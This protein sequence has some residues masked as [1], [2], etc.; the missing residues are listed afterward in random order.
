MS[1]RF[2]DSFDHYATAS[3]P[4]KWTYVLQGT[5][6]TTIAAGS[7][8]NG[9]QSLHFPSG[10]TSPTVTKTFDGNQT[11][12]VVGF[13]MKLSALP[14]AYAPILTFLQAQLQ[15][16]TLGINS[17]G[18]LDLRRGLNTA[19]TGGASTNTISTGTWYYV[20]T[21][22]KPTT[23][24]AASSCYV[25]VGGV[26][27]LT[28]T[29]G[30]SLQAASGPGASAFTITT[31]IGTGT[32]DI[33]DLY[34]CD[35]QAGATG[36]FGNCMVQVLYPD[37][38]SFVGYS[39]WTASTGT[40]Y[41]CLD[42]AI[43]NDDADYVYCATTGA[44]ATPDIV[45][46]VEMSQLTYSP[47]AITGIQWNMYARKSDAGYR[48]LRRFVRSH[49]GGATST[50]TTDYSVGIDYRTFSEAFDGDPCNG[51]AAWTR[52]LVENFEAGMVLHAY[53]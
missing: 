27:W 19:V 11:A 2:I 14:G 10:G 9:T 46:M 25:N 51:G 43:A 37:T 39:D 48:F 31:P 23:S 24:V 8:R 32:M 3:I 13:A 6:A 42:E 38:D 35:D 17:T 16:C 41:T 52:T 7:G 36:P 34:V 20:E 22:V 30:Q 21:A 18:T 15:Q 29:A 50:G 12:W 28:V 47:A 40:W 33:D 49:S 5:G 1:L 44:P 26:N 53:G 4:S 45:Q